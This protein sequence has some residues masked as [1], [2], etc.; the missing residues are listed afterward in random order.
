M[1]EILLWTIFSS[2]HVKYACQSIMCK[3]CCFYFQGAFACLKARH[4]K[5]IW[6]IS[7][8]FVST[9]GA[10]I[11]TTRAYTNAMYTLSSWMP[12]HLHF[13]LHSRLATEHYMFVFVFLHHKWIYKPSLIQFGENMSTRFF[14][15]HDE[16]MILIKEEFPQATQRVM[17]CNHFL[18]FDSITL[19]IQHNGLLLGKRIAPLVPK[20][21][22]TWGLKMRKTNIFKQWLRPC[23]LGFLFRTDG[24]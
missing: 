20:V 7:S 8:C 4:T 10:C 11:N 22:H 16:L 13:H 2:V 14:E 9:N 19:F 12:C 6:H 1:W 23:S 5:N 21:K 3:H 18:R 17:Q 24:C 15:W